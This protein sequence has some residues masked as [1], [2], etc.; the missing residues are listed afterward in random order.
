MTERFAIL[1]HP[2]DDLFEPRC[3][4]KVQLLLRLIN[5]RIVML[6]YNHQN[7]FNQVWFIM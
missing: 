1:M 5:K 6:K 2:S 4:L 3:W 7:E